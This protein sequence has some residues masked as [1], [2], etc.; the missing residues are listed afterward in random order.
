MHREDERPED[1]ARLSRIA[2]RWSLVAE[3]HSREEEDAVATRQ[4]LF[5]RYA[6]ASYRYLLGAVHD[7]EAAEELCHEF[8]V[9][10]LSGDFHRADPARGRF[11]D[12]VR[13]ALINLAND[14]HRSRRDHPQRLPESLQ[15]AARTDETQS[16]RTFEDCLREELLDRAWKALKEANANYHAALHLKVFEPELSSRE[17]AEEINRRTGKALSPDTI[18]KTLERARTKFAELLV[19]EVAR[20]GQLGDPDQ[21]RS[22][23][24]QLDLLKYCRSALDRWRS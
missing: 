19:E 18:R 14:H 6:A 7:A 1:D 13:K 16:E 20:L 12:Y 9:R 4:A 17:I 8:A 21:L 2:T 15:L 24:E 3:A 5:E 11:R 22:E 10:F 23:L